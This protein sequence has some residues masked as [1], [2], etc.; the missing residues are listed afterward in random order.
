MSAMS[1]QDRLIVAL[2]VPSVDDAMRFVDELDGLVNFYKVGLQLLMTGGFERLL[3]QLVQ[4]KKRV[5][6]DLKLPN[7][8]P[9]TIRSTASLAADLGVTFVTLSASAT[10][11][12]VVN[13]VAGRGTRSLPKLLV[14]PL[15]S[16]QSREEYTSLRGLDVSQFEE[17]LRRE[18]RAAIGH[19]VDGF[20]VSGQ[21]IAL[22]RG[23]YPDAVLVSPGIRLAGSTTDD[24]QRSCTPAEAI[25]LGA[26]HI[27]VGRPIRNAPDRRDVAQR[28]LDELA[29]AHYPKS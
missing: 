29:G 26:D 23:W 18:T 22:L 21:E 12:T 5:F 4:G 6:V 9:E 20:I 25:E 27:V 7:D 15:L 24:H 3:R 14:V 28:I 13:A 10:P 1:P 16:S 11:V 17:V 19:N 8:I 2:D